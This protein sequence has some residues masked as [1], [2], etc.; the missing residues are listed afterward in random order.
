MRIRFSWAW[1][2]ALALSVPTAAQ[3]RF[4]KATIQTAFGSAKRGNGGELVIDGRSVRFEKGDSE[5]FSLSPKALTEIFYSRVS[6]RRIKTAMVVSPL[7][8]LTKGHKHYLTMSFNDGEDAVGAVEFQLH[9]SNYRGV[10]RALEQATGLRAKYDQEG[11]KGPVQNALW[12]GEERRPAPPRR[13]L[14]AISSNP[15]GAEI[16]IDDS[17]AGISPRKK[18][19]SAGKY[20]I[21]F[22][23][24]GYADWERTIVV[25]A[26]QELTI[27]ANLEP[28]GVNQP[29]AIERPLDPPVQA[30]R[31]TSKI[32]IHGPE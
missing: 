7:L 10:L 16:T 11:V 27:E 31:T 2:L 30:S 25:D 28:L 6:G 9:K 14:V 24:K 22:S 4:E 26:G 1:L 15:S 20:K 5:Y 32:T 23:M 21:R 8:L 12:S 17:F 19:L 29:P 3:V 13:A 18:Q